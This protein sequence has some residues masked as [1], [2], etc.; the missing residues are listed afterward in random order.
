[1]AISP[2]ACVVGTLALVSFTV[3]G[4]FLL[5]VSS[6]FMHAAVEAR[7][8]SNEELTADSCSP[9]NPL[10]EIPPWD[11]RQAERTNNPAGM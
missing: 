4:A 7:P 10:E 3:Q 5:L 11:I 1:V 2:F 8:Q 6:A 9:I